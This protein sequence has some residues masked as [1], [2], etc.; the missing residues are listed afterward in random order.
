MPAK[1]IGISMNKGYEGTVARSADSI[2]VNRV[3]S[4][5]IPFGKAVIL[6]DNGNYAI[7]STG[8]TE[9]DIV[10]ISVREVIQ[11][12]TFDPQ[13]N[14]GYLVKTP[15][16]VLTRGVITVKCGKGTP[17]AGAPVFV[18][19]TEDTTDELNPGDFAA[20]AASTAANTVTV[21]N[22][23]WHSEADSNG[24]AELLITTRRD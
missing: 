24:I 17:K 16:D 18:C 11:A 23:L 13:T 15:T 2:I 22:M 19:I 7:P 12:N 6:D 10:G 14:T 20:Q 5:A 8:K 4:T 21:A 1:V 9:A 3:S